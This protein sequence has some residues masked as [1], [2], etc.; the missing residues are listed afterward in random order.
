MIHPS[1]VSS[2][3]VLVSPTSS[4]VVVVVHPFGLSLSFIITV[5]VVMDKQARLLYYHHHSGQDL[6]DRHASLVT[7][8]IVLGC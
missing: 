7:S 1:S 4:V 6:A 5:V 3:L 8:Y 2:H